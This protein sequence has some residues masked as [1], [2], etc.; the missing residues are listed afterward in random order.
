M[1]PEDLRRAEER[2][3][4]QFFK[5]T[6]GINTTNMILFDAAGCLRKFENPEDICRDF[7]ECRRE[8]YKKRKLV[9]I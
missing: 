9:I 1:K 2:G 5:L 8:I 7:F 6:A 3:L 4:Y